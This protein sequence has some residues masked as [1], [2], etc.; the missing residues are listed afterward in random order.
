M[1]EYKGEHSYTNEQVNEDGWVV[2]VYP[3]MFGKRVVVYHKD[4]NYSLPGSLCAGGDPNVL[5]IMYASIY[6]W[7]KTR[8][9]DV[10]DT[11]RHLHSLEKVRPYP[12]SPKLVEAINELPV[13]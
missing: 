12:K 8:P 11:L 1:K 2:G 10:E 7:L 3:V 4:D 6:S 5:A 9:K 13:E